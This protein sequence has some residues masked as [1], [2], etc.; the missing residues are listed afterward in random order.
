[1]KTNSFGIFIFILFIFPYHLI[2]GVGGFIHVLGVGSLVFDFVIS[3]S[4]RI[5]PKKT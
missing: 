1:L 5:L 2:L 4:W 3:K